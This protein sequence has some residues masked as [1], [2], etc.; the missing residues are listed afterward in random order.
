MGA[1]GRARAATL[2]R[3]HAMQGVEAMVQKRAVDIMCGARLLRGVEVKSFS[4]QV[5]LA[6]AG[7]LKAIAVDAGV[8]GRIP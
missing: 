3:I 7:A 4:G 2:K 1:L 8:L 5:V 6:H